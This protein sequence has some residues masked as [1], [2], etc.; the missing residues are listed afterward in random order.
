MPARVDYMGYAIRIKRSIRR[1]MR[2]DFM[3][4]D[5]D[6][7]MIAL[8]N[9]Y[10]AIKAKSPC[11]YLQAYR[12]TCCYIRDK[13]YNRRKHIPS[14]QRDND[15]RVAKESVTRVT[16]SGRDMLGR[17]LSDDKGHL[18]EIFGLGLKA[19]DVARVSGVTKSRVS[20]C[21]SAGM[22]RAREM[23]SA[24]GVTFDDCVEEVW[25]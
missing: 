22:N 20:Q 14:I 18:L 3:F 21:K 10:D 25:R 13:S 2:V 19:V 23:V 4:A 17:I 1:S 8:M 15:I 5:E 7:E 16:G 6:I 12:A 11:L 24:M 9:V